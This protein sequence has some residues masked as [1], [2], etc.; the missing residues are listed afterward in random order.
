MEEM[1]KPVPA[2]REVLYKGSSSIG[3]SHTLAFLN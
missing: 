2:D 1:E 3:Q